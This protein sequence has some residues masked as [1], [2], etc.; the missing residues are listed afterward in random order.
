MDPATSG[1]PGAGGGGLG[2]GGGNL[3][4]AFDPSGRYKD[5]VFLNYTFKRFDGLTQ[6]GVPRP[7]ASQALQ[8][9]LQQQQQQHQPVGPSPDVKH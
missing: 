3:E 4:D 7:L 5:W 8:Q 1:A 9:Q 2:G 6:R